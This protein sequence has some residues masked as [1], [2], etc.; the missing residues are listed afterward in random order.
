MTFGL[1][2]QRLTLDDHEPDTL[3]GWASAC[4]D[5]LRAGQRLV[6]LFGRVDTSGTRSV[7][8]LTAIFMAPPDSACTLAVVRAVTPA[9]ASYPAL[10]IEF[11]AAQSHERE[12]WEQTGI[13]PVG[14][15]W[16]KPIRFEGERQQRMHEYPFFQM[17]G[18]GIHE[19]G[20]GPIHA[21]VIEPGHFRF[22]CMGETVRHLEIQFGYQHR[23]VET[24]LLHRPARLLAPVVESI[25]GDSSIAYVS[26]YCAAIES[27]ADIDAPWPVQ[28]L[29]GIALELERVAIHLSTMTGLAT[30]IAFLQGAGTYGRLRTAVINAVQMICGN[31]FGRGWLRPGTAKGLTGDMRDGLIRTLQAFSRDFSEINAR[32][33]G[34]WSVRTRLQGV[35]VV[36][37][38]TARELGL[39]GLVARASGVASDLRGMPGDRLHQA[40]PIR[41]MTV[42]D[43]DCWA[44]LV[45]RMREIEASVDW[46][47]VVL[48]DAG[49]DLEMPAITGNALSG[50]PLRPNSLVAALVEGV[51][52]TVVQVLETGA[53]GELAHVKVQDPSLPNWFGLAMAMRGTGISDFPICNKSF[54]LSYCGND[55]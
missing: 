23:G 38:Q 10:S 37:T 19:V 51:R 53:Q 20:V 28:V 16:L 50:Q 33:C 44:R 26:G 1:P 30:D 7:V 31:R 9:G 4:G 35:G 24:L 6:T 48:G 46:L 36:T 27:L 55:L 8:R 18:R 52:G 25:C 45:L 13:E 29:R 49:L 43:G 21:G 54:D 17:R 39:V 47:C 11:P 5:R 15:P 12:L 34:S 40:Y 14:H 3:A 41:S 22:M 42:P 32:M 2:V